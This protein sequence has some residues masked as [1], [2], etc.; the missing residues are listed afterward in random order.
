VVVLARLIH[1]LVE[2]RVGVGS[3]RVL[4]RCLVE[5]LV[6]G[7]IL[8]RVEMASCLTRL[9]EDQVAVGMQ[10]VHRLVVGV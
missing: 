6:V 1:E 3:L 4:M 9:V 5:G 8:G 7:G 10:E 2:G